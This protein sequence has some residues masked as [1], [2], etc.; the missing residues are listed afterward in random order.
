MIVPGVLEFH[1]LGQAINVKHHPAFFRADCFGDHQSQR[2]LVLAT[3]YILS[4]FS[5]KKGRQKF[6]N[7]VEE[8]ATAKDDSFMSTTNYITNDSFISTNMS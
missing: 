1:R 4:M 5:N 2:E 6:P 8:S 7:L 3:I